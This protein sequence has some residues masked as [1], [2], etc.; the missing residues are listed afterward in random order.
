[1]VTCSMNIVADM[2]EDTVEDMEG[3]FFTIHN[4]ISCEADALGK[5]TELHA[6]VASSLP[7]DQIT[8][9]P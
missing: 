5:R 1:M 3:S 4:I 2:V 9:K 7:P 8:I 6:S